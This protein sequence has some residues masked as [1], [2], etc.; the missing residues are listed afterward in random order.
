M[1][2]TKRVL[3]MSLSERKQKAFEILGEILALEQSKTKWNS[4][5][6][7][8]AVGYCSSVSEIAQVVNTTPNIDWEETDSCGKTIL[9]I[10][11]G[12]GSNPEC[13]MVVFEYLCAQGAHTCLFAKDVFGN[14][15]GH[16]A[17][18]FL[19]DEIRQQISVTVWA[20]YMSEVLQVMNIRPLAEIVRVY[21]CGD[22]APGALA[23]RRAVEVQRLAKKRKRRR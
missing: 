20:R 4:N 19:L 22:Y 18:S 1:T 23:H 10:C 3:K 21:L 16:F 5:A 17:D 9:H 12:P 15:G 2:R 13:R 8:H 14:L 6:L 11:M 7:W